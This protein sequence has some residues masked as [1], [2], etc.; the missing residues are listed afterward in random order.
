MTA[1]R[2]RPQSQGARELDDVTLARAK[3]GQ[4]AACRTLVQCYQRPIFALLTR[5]LVGRGHDVTIEDLAQECFLRVFRGLPNFRPDGRAK[6]STWILTI[7]TRLALDE[8]RRRS[9]VVLCDPLPEPAAPNPTQQLEQRAVL[10][11]SADAVA[12]L[13]TQLQAALVLRV[14]HE[15]S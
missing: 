10:R 5:M 8:L 3:L 2:I 1:P 12:H 4:E 15:L 6:L 14:F 11:W 7:A 9:P 13:P